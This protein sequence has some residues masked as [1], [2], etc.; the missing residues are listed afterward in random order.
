MILP[1]SNKNFAMMKKYF[2]ISSIIFITVLVKGQNNYPDIVLE[3]SEGKIV[4][5]LYHETPLH[6]ENFL[7]LVNEGYYNGLLFHRV[8]KNFMIQSG[9]PNS[10]NAASRTM[11]GSGG[12]SYTIPAE[13]N[14][15]YYHKKGALAAA[16]QGDNLNP[17]KESSGSQ[18]YIVQG[19]IANMSQLESL[20]KKGLHNPF[21][22]DEIQTYTTQGGTP[23]LDGQYT[24]FGEVISGLD[25]IEKIALVQTDQRDR[26]LN[27]VRILKTYTV[28]KS[29]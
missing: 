11:L 25:V 12:P 13:F 21:T 20:L 27:D 9:D 16:R 17:K 29:K 14:P 22:P 1:L 5:S 4:L 10:K 3:T 8:I 28:K 19:Q 24:V 6:S 2:L 18:F 26:P 7:K 23:F 15:K